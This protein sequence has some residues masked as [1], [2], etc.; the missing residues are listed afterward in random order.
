MD[1]FIYMIVSY[2]IIIT[3][4]FPY[5]DCCFICK[6]PA[7]KKCLGC[8]MDHDSYVL[9]SEQLVYFCNTCCSQVHGGSETSAPEQINRRCDKE[10]TDVFPVLNLLS[11]ICIETSHYVCFTR[12]VAHGQN[13][14]IFFDSMADR[15]CKCNQT[16]YE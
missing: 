6:N 5:K 10:A 7:Q 3:V 8:A 2:M 14:W 15:V 4:L 9:K 11:V 16:I 12:S 1:S 13:K